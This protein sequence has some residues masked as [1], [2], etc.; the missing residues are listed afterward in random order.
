MSLADQPIGLDGEPVEPTVKLCQNCGEREAGF[1]Q[2]GRYCQECRDAGVG[3]KDR[4][5]AAP[6]P[7]FVAKP[8]KAAPSKRS[9][10]GKLHAKLYDAH[11]GFTMSVVLLTNPTVLTPPMVDVLE[12]RSNGWASATVGL[13][14]AD[15]RIAELL[16]K[17]LKAG[18]WGAFALQTAGSVVTIGA[19]TGRLKVPYGAVAFLAPELVPFM[20][21]PEEVSTNGAQAA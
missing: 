7:P 1:G 11:F 17:I 18:V 3:K 2:F 21:Q 6:P 8:A 19:L 15:A 16:E 4:T 10:A 14:E 13:A 5:D 20:R 9:T 12:G